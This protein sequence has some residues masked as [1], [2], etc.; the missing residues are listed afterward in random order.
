MAG[1]EQDTYVS[2]YE[3]VEGVVLDRGLIKYNS[4]KR[5]T[6]KLLLN[7]F[8]GKFGDSNNHRVHKLVGSGV[9]LFKYYLI[10]P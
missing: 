8:W 3:E 1:T 9:D 4:R 2:E 7:S 10:L 6:N 5:A